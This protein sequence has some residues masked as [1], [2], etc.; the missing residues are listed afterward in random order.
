MS[1]LRRWTVLDFAIIQQKVLD[2]SEMFYK[3]EE[4]QIDL[5]LQAFFRAIAH[6]LEFFPIK[7]ISLLRTG[8]LETS[9]RDQTCGKTAY[10]LVV[11]SPNN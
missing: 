1:Y 3:S 8:I 4:V 9:V 10:R 2:V 6:C 5:G 7:N 11:K